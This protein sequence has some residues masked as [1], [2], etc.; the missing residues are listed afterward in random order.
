MSSF[1]NE[2]N[3][4]G[5]GTG[6]EGLYVTADMKNRC[7]GDDSVVFSHHSPWLIVICTLS[8]GSV[9]HKRVRK[10]A[11]L[12]KHTHMFTHNYIYLNTHM[13]GRRGTTLPR[14]REGEK[15]S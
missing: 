7:V 8:G 9:M 2:V 13:L 5:E 11:N 10:H 12:T 4:G 14:A 6:D 3:N 1:P 15:E